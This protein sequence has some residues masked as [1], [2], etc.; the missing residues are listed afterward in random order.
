M[1]APRYSL[2]SF[3]NPIDGALCALSTCRIESVV[4][5]APS[6]SSKPIDFGRSSKVIAM[7]R[8][9]EVRDDWPGAE[10]VTHTA[11]S[12]TPRLSQA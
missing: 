3:T 5:R 7:V 8:P 12:P 1:V 6:T 2:P 10:A 11:I 4:R 9:P